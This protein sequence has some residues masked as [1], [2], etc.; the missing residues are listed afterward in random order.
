VLNGRCGKDGDDVPLAA[1][2]HHL[3]LA[4]TD[5]KIEREDKLS[6]DGREAL[7]TELTAKLDGVEKH[8][9]V[10]VLKKNGCVYD[11]VHVAPPGFSKESRDRFVGFVQGFST[12]AP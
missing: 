7:H 3:F 1:L 12:I 2:T 10:F 11:F 5:R 8:F 4:F 6:L 9:I